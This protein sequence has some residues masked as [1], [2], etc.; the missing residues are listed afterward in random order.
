MQHPASGITY[1]CFL[2][3]LKRAVLPIYQQIIVLGASCSLAAWQA[4]IRL[5]QRAGGRGAGWLCSSGC[6]LCCWGVPCA[7]G[8][9]GAHVAGQDTLDFWGVNYEPHPSAL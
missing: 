3:A 7:V 6:P 1:F 4:A 5:W 2:P 8:V 9:S